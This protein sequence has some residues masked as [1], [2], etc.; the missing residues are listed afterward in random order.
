[1]STSNVTY[2]LRF[3][4]V[5][6][7]IAI[8]TATCTSCTTPPPTADP[9]LGEDHDVN[10]APAIPAIDEPTE[11]EAQASDVPAGKT[12]DPRITIGPYAGPTGTVHSLQ[13]AGFTPN[14]VVDIS[15]YYLATGALVLSFQVEVDHT[16]DGLAGIISEPGDDIGEYRVVASDQ[17]T[18]LF[19][20]STYLTEPPLR[21]TNP[22]ISIGPYAGPIG[23]VHT[24]QL[25]DFTPDGVVDINTY[26]LAT[27]AL[28]LSFQVQVD[29]TGYALTGVISEP[30]DDIGEYRVVASDQATGLVAQSIFSTQRAIPSASPQIR[31]DPDAV[32][33][34]PGDEGTQPLRDFVWIGDDDWT[35]VV[36]QNTGGIPI[37]IASHEFTSSNAGEFYLGA[38]F[39]GARLSPQQSCYITLVFEPTST[40]ER[41]ANLLVRTK[42]TAY[43]TATSEVTLHGYA[44]VNTLGLSATA[45]PLTNLSIPDC[46][47]LV[48]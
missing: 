5:L 29:H 25:V 43:G 33:F 42:E 14:G 32:D 2:V 48:Y 17:A 40:G 46:H 3:T 13:L 27:G 15:T 6:L 30:G 18:G 26:Y 31:I 16:G 11:G 38:S 35:K 22:G 4:A 21:A 8:T 19:A 44:R 7:A 10:V 24:L 41:R 45:E 39:A 34:T 23:T 28:V 9:L 1:M 12:I 37:V 20:E 36:L 47:E